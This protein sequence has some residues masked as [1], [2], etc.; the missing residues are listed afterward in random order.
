MNRADLVVTGARGLAGAKSLL[1]GS[2]AQ[3]TLLHA[4]CN[5]LTV[6]GAS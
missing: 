6:K 5:V 2:V 4:P 3:R 1:L